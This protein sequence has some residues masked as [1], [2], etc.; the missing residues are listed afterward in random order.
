MNLFKYARENLKIYK[1]RTVIMVVTLVLVVTASVVGISIQSAT[2]DIATQYR[3]QIGAQVNIEADNKKINKG[4]KSP[5]RIT[6]EQYEQIAQLEY[7]KKYSYL[8]ELVLRSSQLKA[9]GQDEQKG[10]DKSGIV[11][12]D[13][14]KL[15][16]PTLK[17][18]GGAGNVELPEFKDGTRSIIEGEAPQN[19]FEAIISQE[20]AKLNGIK[21]GDTIK[22][23]DI[24]GKVEQE[25]K[26]TGIYEDNTVEDGGTGIDM[27]IFNRRNE[28]ITTFESVAPLNLGGLN[29]VRATFEINDP[30]DFDAFYQAVRGLGISEDYKISIDQKS[31]DKA[32]GP[33]NNLN[34]TVSYFMMIILLIAGGVLMLLSIL[35]IKERQ[36]EIGVL[37]AMG[38]KK[39][40]VGMSFILESM[41]ILFI[42]MIIGFGIGAVITKPIASSLLDSQIQQMNDANKD[43]DDASILFAPDQSQN[44]KTVDSL[45]ASIN[46]VV[47]LKIASL[48]FAIII[49][50][51]II[52]I[53]YIMRFQPMEI[54]RKK[55]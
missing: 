55:N 40:K 47:V 50:T 1:Y 41:M 49:F 39:T 24:E 36:Y 16:T 2:Q 19:K 42:A 8:T 51:N 18:I 25:F 7:V 43:E 37:R 32:V 26:V 3:N 15:D 30:K 17:V 4:G 9:V 22:L 33:I 11:G 52:N 29:T 21:V 14:V 48:G 13:G 20:L 23:N 5:V 34:S 10:E 6:A 12:A 53:I 54:M 38:M 44:V 31:F 27:P 46:A 28:I 35:A 45:N